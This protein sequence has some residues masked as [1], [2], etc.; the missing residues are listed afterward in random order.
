M[1]ESRAELCEDAQRALAVLNMHD[2]ET[3]RDG[4]P[5]WVFEPR[6]DRGEPGLQSV[7]TADERIDVELRLAS[8][9]ILAELSHVAHLVLLTLCG[10]LTRHVRRAGV[11]FRRGESHRKAARRHRPSRGVGGHSNPCANGAR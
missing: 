2:R 6:L 1:N 9:A 4:W 3:Y 5:S 7:D 10:R 8:K 11:S